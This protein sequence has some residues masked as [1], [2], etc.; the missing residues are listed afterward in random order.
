[1]YPQLYATVDQ[2]V[3]KGLRLV[4]NLPEKDQLIKMKEENLTVCD[5]ELL[6]SIL[7]RKANE[8]CNIFGTSAWTPRRVDMV[9]WTYGR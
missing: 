9:L 6:I 4:E 2:F 5:G 7:T 1:M 8:N 3:V